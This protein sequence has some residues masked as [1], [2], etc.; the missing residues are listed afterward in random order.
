MRKSI[1][2]LLEIAKLH[3]CSPSIKKWIDENIVTISYSS[4]VMS[5]EI[6]MRAR[7]AQ[8]MGLQ[9]I[10]LSDKEIRDEYLESNTKERFHRLTAFVLK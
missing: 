5:D 10:D 7:S 8:A 4:R 1:E 3:Q 6:F 2:S 9:L